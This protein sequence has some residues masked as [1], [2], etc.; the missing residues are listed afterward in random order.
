M[1]LCSQL[2]N[3]MPHLTVDEG[4][5]QEAHI[6]IF[7]FNEGLKDER[8]SGQHGG[9]DLDFHLSRCSLRI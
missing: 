5:M 9:H 4:L 3:Q 7:G 1:P 8:C 2:P 6:Y